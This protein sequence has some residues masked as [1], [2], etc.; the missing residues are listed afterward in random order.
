MRD[1]LDASHGDQLATAEYR[2][3]FA[4]HFWAI[5]HAD[6]WKLERRQVFQEPGDDS[7][8][9]FSRGDWRKAL[10]LL[11]QRRE[12]LQAYYE[13]IARAGF[14]TWRVRV[15]EEPVTPYLRWELRL[16]RL[17][18]EYGGLVRIVGPDAVRPLEVNGALPEVVTLGLDVMYEVRYDERG[19]LAGGVRYI[20]S[21]LVTRWRALIAKLYAAGEDITSFFDRNHRSLDLPR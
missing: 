7:W 9:A 20:D 19:V 2:R 14:R 10:Q 13:R 6:F 11:E 18:H 3:D 21:G 4:E 8:E 15:V 5:S 17:R 1:L 12:S 16:L